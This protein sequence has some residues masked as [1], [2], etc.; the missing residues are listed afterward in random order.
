MASLARAKVAITSDGVTIAS[1]KYRARLAHI[2]W[3]ELCLRSLTSAV[4]LPAGPRGQRL[5]LANG[6]VVRMK[7]AESTVAAWNES[8]AV[9]NRG[10]LAPAPV[11]R[12]PRPKAMPSRAAH[13]EAVLEM[14]GTALLDDNQIIAAMLSTSFEEEHGHETPARILG[15]LGEEARE[16]AERFVQRN[17]LG[18][19]V[20]RYVPQDVKIAVAVR[21]GGRCVARLPDGSR[22]PATSSLHLDHRFIPFRL[23]GTQKAWNL[24]LLCS[25]HNW[26]KGGFLGVVW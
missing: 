20:S 4:L 23:G 2:E 8:L 1:G 26:G 10:A 12:I 11:A 3:S 9:L 24:C 14:L 25:R 5:A 19:R 21:D 13:T 18:D 7:R 6:L 15:A 16:V 22:C 17:L